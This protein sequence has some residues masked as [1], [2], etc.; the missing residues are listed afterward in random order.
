MAVTASYSPAT[1]KL[2]LL[3]DALA[4]SIIVSRNVG[5]TLFVNGGAVPIAGGPATIAPVPLDASPFRAPP[6]ASSPTSAA[7]YSP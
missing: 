6:C 3:G 1:R 2:T 5:G 4:N 7:V